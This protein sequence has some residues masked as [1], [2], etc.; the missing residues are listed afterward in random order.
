MAFLGTV[1]PPTKG[2]NRR[3]AVLERKVGRRRA[4]LQ[5]DA[6][7]EGPLRRGETRAPTGSADLSLGSPHSPTAL[8]S[9]PPQPAETG[10]QGLREWRLQS[11]SRLPVR[12]GVAALIR[13]AEL[14]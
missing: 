7:I 12:S 4:R 8:G 6:G 1:E 3:T 9:F 5:V 10:D 13:A 2:R 14:S 11:R